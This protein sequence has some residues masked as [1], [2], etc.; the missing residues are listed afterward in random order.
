MLNDVAYYSR[1]SDWSAL[2]GAEYQ[3]FGLF[4]QWDLIPHG[5]GD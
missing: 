3:A 1:S 2:S 5:T 4:P